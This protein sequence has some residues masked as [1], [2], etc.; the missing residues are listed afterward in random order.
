[1][2]IFSLTEEQDVNNSPFTDYISRV[3]LDLREVNVVLRH[4]N[5]KLHALFETREI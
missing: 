1:M 4:E 5:V 3:A 2:E